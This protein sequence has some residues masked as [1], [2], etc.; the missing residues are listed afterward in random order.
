MNQS[1][2]FLRN[3]LILPEFRA[4]L[5][6]LYLITSLSA[7]SLNVLVLYTMWRTPSLHKPSYLLL[8]NLALSDFM[9]GAIGE[10]LIILTHFTYLKNLTAIYCSVSASAQVVG[11]WLGSSCLYTLTLISVD[12]LLAIRLKNRYRSFVT[13][14]RIWMVTVPYWVG[15]LAFLLALFIANVPFL[16]INIISS[17]VLSVLLT[18]IIVC[19]SMAFYTLKKLT[20]SVSS[21][22]QQPDEEST[23]FDVSKYRRSLNTMLLVLMTTLLMYF[24]Y[25]ASAVTYSIK[26]G[27]TVDQNSYSV[28]SYEMLSTSELIIA[29][30]STVNPLLYL[31][32]MQDIRE[33]V[34][35]M[36]KKILRRKNQSD[37]EE[38]T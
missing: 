32:R 6:T 19:Y 16:V 24:P 22:S 7:V 18:T 20:S 3:H 5:C 8:A 2:S 4:S 38:Q 29:M 36:V 33:A 15:I 9:Y 23:N 11:Y 21:S 28:I 12:R 25:F 30:N 34:K 31:W 13:S 17:L 26:N 37:E 27:E 1:C 10:P 35:I 14:R